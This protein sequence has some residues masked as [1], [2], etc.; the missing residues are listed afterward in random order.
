MN[1]TSD[2]ELVTIGRL[3]KPFGIKGEV[4]VESLTDIPGC[5]ENL[6]HV[7]LNP[8][9]GK[10]LKTNV[11]QARI[12][13]RFYLLR[14]SAFSSPEEAAAFRGALI[15]IPQESIPPS[16]AEHFYEFELIGLSVCDELGQNLGSVEEIMDL[17]QHSVFVVRQ[18]EIEHLIPGTR[19]IVKRID[20]EN[21]LITVA[22][23]EQWGI[24]NAM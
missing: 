22:P 7:S 2:T 16:S 3:L 18:E 10:V 9:T 11:I 24:P 21:R 1:T 4:R 6:P 8:S 17:P 19:Q 23:I 14:F 12:S 15:Q 13:G 5:F 20:V